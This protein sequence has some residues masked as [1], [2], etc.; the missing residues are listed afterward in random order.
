MSNEL[1]LVVD[2]EAGIT[3]FVAYNLEQAGYRVRVESTRRCL[4]PRDHVETRPAD[5][6]S[7][8]F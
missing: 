2:D 8:H 5:R 3:D 7:F 6:A 4:F 1:I